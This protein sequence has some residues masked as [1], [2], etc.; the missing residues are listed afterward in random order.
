[1]AHLTSNRLLGVLLIA[2]AC[3]PGAPAGD[4]E[5]QFR[6]D[7]RHTGRYAGSELPN[8]AGLAWRAALDGP[9][10]GAPAVTPDRI[11]VATDRGSVYALD[12]AAGRV[13]WRAG[14]GSPA[15]STPAVA[16]G[17]VAVTT[18]DGRVHGLSAADGVSRWH[19]DPVGEAPFPW[20]H[21]SG[22]VYLSSVAVLG[23]AL[24]AGRPDG[25][26]IRLD[27]ATGRIRWTAHTDGRVRGTPAVT[28]DAV[29][30]GSADG[31][32]YAFDAV[33]GD[34]V[35]RFD[36]EG[37]TLESKNFGYDRR[38]VQAS[39]AVDSTTVYIGARDGFLYAIDR[40]TGKQRWR[41]DHQISW[42]NSSPA[43]GLGFVYAGS[44]DGH[45]VQ[46]VDL[47]TGQERW[48]FPTLST[49]WSSPALVGATLYTM[50]SPGVLYAADARTGAVRWRYRLPAR[51][52]SSVVPADS[53]LYVGADD[54]GLYAV[55]TT[56]G[57]AVERYVYWDTT[58][59]GERQ[60][61]GDQPVRRYLVEHGFQLVGNDS[62]AALLRDRGDASHRRIVFAL[63]VLPAAL[64][65]SAP[66]ALRGFL[67]AGGRAVWLGLPPGLWPVDRQ[68]GG[69]EITGI[70]RPA[71]ERVFGVSLAASQFDVTMSWPTPAGRAIGLDRPQLSSWSAD[72][73]GLVPLALD[74]DGRAAAWAKVYPGNGLLMRVLGGPWRDLGP[75]E[76]AAIEL[77]ADVATERITQA[78]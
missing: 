12:R 3:Q 15:S 6:G 19:T 47:V 26:V 22:D 41:Y 33:G 10:R 1:M 37:R 72:T 42:V 9:I 20:G 45:F 73:T 31:S 18:K 66:A 34:Q 4:V 75:A 5:S 70:D 35:W 78:K 13:L 16:G 2:T 60:F 43:V 74:P 24:Y 52:F 39:P 76:L 11:Y 46:A 7:A 36:T 21:E 27:A 56:S 38:T 23:E 49:S 25:T 77:A 32:V 44:S 14:V 8:F 62:L 40:T 50:E 28:D 53:M 58:A 63:D 68:A 67:D 30:V 59:V 64:G 61:F 57:P 71:V 48:R 51:T 65:D 55:A 69:R 54:G 17:I 29:F